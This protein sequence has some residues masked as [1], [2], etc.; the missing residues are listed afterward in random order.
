MSSVVRVRLS[1]GEA[2]LGS[3]PAADV[4]NLLLGA[5]RA[6]ARATGGVL[7]RPIKPTG[8]WGRAIEEAVRFRLVGIEEGSVVGILELPTVEPDPSQLE[9]DPSTLGETALGYALRTAAGE[10]DDVDVARAFVK[11]LDQVGV[12]SR[13]EAVTFETDLPNVPR[14]VVIDAPARDRLAGLAAAAPEPKADTLVGVLFEA[15]FEAF[16]ARLRAA[17]G[18][19]VLVSFDEDQANDIKRALRG[20]AEVVGEVSYDPATSQA[21]KVELRSIAQAVQLEMGLE[22]EDFWSEVSIDQLQVERGVEPV[23]D[24]TVL[25]GQEITD[26]EAEALLAALER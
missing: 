22:T 12:G 2:R 7:R 8:R 20:R 26:E 3:I 5:Q 13:Y 18:R 6:M 25:T 14:Q 16:T 17:D 21:V 4:A 15:D 9:L 24:P 23:A 10:A 1:G 19:L 11:L